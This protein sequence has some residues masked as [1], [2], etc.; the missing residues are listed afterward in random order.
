MNKTKSKKSNGKSRNVI[1]MNNSHVLR[2]VIYKY[3]L[4]KFQ[5]T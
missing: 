2:M 5:K 1:N 4:K 3:L